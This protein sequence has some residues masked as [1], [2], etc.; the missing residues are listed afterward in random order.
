MEFL[1]DEEIYLDKLKSQD[2][3]ELFELINKNRQYLQKTLF[4]LNHST[5]VQDSE[6]F[7]SQADNNFLNK[8]LILGIKTKKLI[9]IIS[10]NRIDCNKKEAEIGYWIDEEEQGRGIVTKSCK[11]LIAS[12]FNDLKLEKIFIRCLIQNVK[13]QSV[14]KRLEFEE[15]YSLQYQ[16]L[17]YDRY[18]DCIFFSKT[19]NDYL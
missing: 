17:L 16:E 13:S 2:S 19:K 15:E 10:F 14:A 12:G 7:I 6:N 5:T 1:V 9:G 4:W 3:S 18:M 8:S 11:A